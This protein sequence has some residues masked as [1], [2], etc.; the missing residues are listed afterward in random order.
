VNLPLRE[1]DLKLPVWPK[2]LFLATIRDALEGFGHF[3]PPQGFP[4]QHL[5]KSPRSLNG[6]FYFIVSEFVEFQST[7]SFL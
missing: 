2:A 3:D 5:L 4:P 7:N 1:A 6:A